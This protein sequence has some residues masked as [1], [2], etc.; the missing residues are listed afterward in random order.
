MFLMEYLHFVYMSDVDQREKTM[1]LPEGGPTGPAFVSGTWS[2]LVNRISPGQQRSI[3]ITGFTGTT[4][5]DVVE[6][7]IK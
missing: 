5:P 2:I 7:K 6:K 3:C 4:I 1:H